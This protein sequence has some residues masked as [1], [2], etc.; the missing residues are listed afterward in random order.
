MFFYLSVCVAK[1]FNVRHSTQLSSF[2]PAIHAFAIQHL[3]VL[4][5]RP[6]NW[7]PAGL[8]LIPVFGM[9]SFVAQIIPRT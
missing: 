6:S 1:N 9:N 2:I 7:R 4:V 5:V 8:G 3:F